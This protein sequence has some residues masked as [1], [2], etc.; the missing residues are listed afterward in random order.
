M[1]EKIYTNDSQI[2]LKK[3]SLEQNRY[4][5]EQELNKQKTNLDLNLSYVLNGY[6][7]SSFRGIS[8][9]SKSK[10]HG[11]NV[12]LT[13]NVPLGDQATVENIQRKLLERELISRQI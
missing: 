2:G 11:M 13:W 5:L 9:F 4:Q 6:S 3:A 12:T 1:I 8:D 10:L 7:K